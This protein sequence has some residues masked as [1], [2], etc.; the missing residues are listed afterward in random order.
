M[1]PLPREDSTVELEL[2]EEPEPPKPKPYRDEEV[3]CVY[4]EMDTT[5]GKALA[6]TTSANV[7]SSEV[8][9]VVE[10]FAPRDVPEEFAFEEPTLIF[11]RPVPRLNPK[12]RTQATAAPANEIRNAFTPLFFFAGWVP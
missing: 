8:V 10:V 11:N 3:T 9:M 5:L 6:A 2:S 7:V 4:T 12:I 1:T